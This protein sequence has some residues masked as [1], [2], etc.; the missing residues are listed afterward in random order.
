[1]KLA[2]FVSGPPRYTHLVL[3]QL[4]NGLAAWRP[5]FLVHLWKED[6]GPK[7]REN[8]VFAPAEIAAAEDVELLLQHRGFGPETYLDRLGDR[9]NSGSPVHTTMGM[10]LAVNQ[11]CHLLATSPD[12]HEYT[13]ILR[14]RTDCALL[15]WDRFLPPD[16]LGSCVWISR[17]PGLPQGWSSDHLCLADRENFFRIWKYP[18]MA[19]IERR[20]L[21]ARRNPERMLG[22]R[23]REVEIQGAVVEERFH[24]YLHYQIVYGEV[25][26]TD[27]QWVRQCIREDRVESIF[28]RS[29]GL[30]EMEQLRAELNLDQVETPRHDPLGNR[31]IFW[32]ILEKWGLKGKRGGARK[33]N[34]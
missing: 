18:K 6:S 21:E 9:S 4:R 2:V 8:R 13:H 14:I 31:K 32:R 10:F 1:M 24:R 30:Q 15:N 33:G 16:D 23:M 20:Y 34:Q 11:L 12:C 28:E 17:N 29:V 25:R 7:K 5:H 26:D 27:P 3:R 22:R 19:E